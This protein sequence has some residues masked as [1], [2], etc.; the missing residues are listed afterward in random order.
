MSWPWQFVNTD[1]AERLA[2]RQTLDRYAGYAQISAFGPIFLVLVYRL[3][4]WAI[5]TFE[6]KRPVYAA[7]PE[8]PARKIRRQSG[9]GAWEARYRLL[10]WWL[11]GDVVLFG[12]SWGRRDEWVFGLA[13]GWWMS[14]LSVLETGNG[15][16]VACSYLLSTQ[17]LRR[18]VGGLPNWPLTRSTTDYLHLTKRVGVIAISQLPL[19]YLLS[20][21]SLNPIAYVLKSSHEDVNRYHRA[22]GRIVYGLLVVHAGLYLNYFVQ[23]GLL[24]EKL[25][26]SRA[27]ITGVIGISSMAALYATAFHVIRNYSYRIFFITHLS[28]SLLIPP[29]I[30]FH[31]HTARIY[32]IEALV[33]FLAD[34]VYRKTDTVTTTA[35][36]ESVPETDLVKIILSVPMH[37]L[38]RF[39]KRPG[40]HVYLQIPGASRLSQSPLSKDY[41]VHEFL[42]NPFTVADVDTE[43]S[44]LTLVARH[45]NGPM[46]STLRQMA[47]D[48]G[49]PVSLS[50]EG[51]Y[52]VSA[53]LP[54]LTGGKF[55]RVLLVAGGI[56]STYTVPLYRAIVADSPN[57]KVQLVWAVRSLSEVAW[58]QSEKS[59]MSLSQD[60]N[61]QIFVTGTEDLASVGQQPQGD[62]VELS[63]LP[64]SKEPKQQRSRPDLKKIV[65]DVFRHGQD[66]RVAVLFCGPAQM[67]RD[68][69][70]HVGSWVHKGRAVLWHSEAFEW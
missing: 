53:H 15:E 37:K 1:E 6:S 21:K 40:S 8:S 27:V 49:R 68:L 7:V 25:T 54:H 2:R 4:F 51:P 12:Q 10:Q 14:V 60:E 29:L 32:L 43:S 9:L 19:Q 26:T 39:R 35:S 56:G 47:E 44:S 46:T 5:K 67:G 33:V 28:V 23:M 36:L 31:A 58:T 20:L 61:I 48:D 38:D 59:T 52:G 16:L 30:W 57:A 17:V 13:W 70:R 66:E 22:L 69:R 65:D 18:Y 62:G 45:L 24:L 50:I 42:F 34:I 55:D 3:A 11:G 64:S 63:P 41:L